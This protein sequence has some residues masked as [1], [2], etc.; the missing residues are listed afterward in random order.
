MASEEKHEHKGITTRIQ[1]R[2]NKNKTESQNKNQEKT[3]HESLPGHVGAK[4]HERYENY[5]AERHE[6]KQHQQELRKTQK[7]AYRKEEV[8][9]AA[10]AGERA[11]QTRYA[12]HPQVKHSVTKNA[13]NFAQG[14]ARSS[15][16]FIFGSS[17]ASSSVYGGLSLF[18]SAP[19]KK[20]APQ[21][22]TRVSKN[23][24]VTITEPIQDQKKVIKQKEQAW[25]PLD[26]INMDQIH[27]P[28]GSNPFD[29]DIIKPSHPKSKRGKH[30]SKRERPNNWR[31]GDLI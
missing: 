25:S 21:R 14:S 26:T 13:S 22:V 29:I 24:T 2:L 19:K 17:G 16:K 27:T 6:K 10:K 4:I 15:E 12:P 28:H 30:K 18:P 3:V 5:Q 23:G 1:E 20:P 8:K 11:A 31:I 9:Q 7:E